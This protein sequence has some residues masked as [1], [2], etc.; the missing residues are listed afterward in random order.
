MEKRGDREERKAEDNGPNLEESQRNKDTN[1]RR[2]SPS[3]IKTSAITNRISVVF[4]LTKMILGWMLWLVS[5]VL[6]CRVVARVLQMVL[7]V[8]LCRCECVA[9]QLLAF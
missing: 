8:L 1:H 7:S 4:S 2:Q 6:L 5:R 9:K 3:L